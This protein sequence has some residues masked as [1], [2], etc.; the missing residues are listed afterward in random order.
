MIFGIKEN[1]IIMIHTV[2][3]CL[4]LQIYL[5]CVC[6]CAAGTH[7]LQFSALKDWK[8]RVIYLKSILVKIR[9]NETCFVQFVYK[10]INTQHSSNYIILGFIIFMLFLL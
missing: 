5:C 4:V 8:A 10:Q 9:P 3:C 2:Y 7:L 6:F 1:I